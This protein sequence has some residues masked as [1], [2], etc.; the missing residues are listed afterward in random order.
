MFETLKERHL[1]LGRTD[2]D[3]QKL[4]LTLFILCHTDCRASNCNLDP[5]SLPRPR[6]VYYQPEIGKL[7]PD[8]K[9]KSTIISLA[10]GHPVIDTII[11]CT[12]TKIY[13]MQTSFSKY[14]HHNKKKTNI[15]TTTIRSRGSTIYK[16][17]NEELNF[18][19]VYVMPLHGM[20]VLVMV[21]LLDMACTKGMFRWK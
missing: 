13:F 20:I 8:Y 18:R 7:P 19:T 11:V 5:I 4:E 9:R 3:W 15:F 2:W 1:V 17:Y 14:S 16:H 21:Y 6:E 12:T 10:N